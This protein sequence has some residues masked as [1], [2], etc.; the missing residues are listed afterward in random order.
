MVTIFPKKREK[1]QKLKTD[2]FS[3]SEAYLENK[4]VLEM[5]W[6]D[7]LDGVSSFSKTFVEKNRLPSL[8]CVNFVF[9][10][11]NS[12]FLTFFSLFV[13]MEHS[14]METRIH[15]HNGSKWPLM[16]LLVDWKK[17]MKA[18]RHLR[19]LRDKTIQAIYSHTRCR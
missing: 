3:I 1:N 10:K 18:P 6:L 4:T 11:Q 15:K 9:R 19:A 17:I 7:Y 13:D 5:V 8:H 12:I 14:S 2:I 16:L